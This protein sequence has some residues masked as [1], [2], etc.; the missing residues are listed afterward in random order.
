MDKLISD[1]LPL[2]GASKDVIVASGAV[3]IA[4]TFKHQKETITEIKADLG[5]IWTVINAM[6]K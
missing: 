4:L 5:N 2:L 3:Y 1:I 6:R